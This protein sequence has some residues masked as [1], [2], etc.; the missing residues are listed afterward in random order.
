MTLQHTET[1]LSAQ[2][3]IRTKYTWLDFISIVMHSVIITWCWVVATNNVLELSQ[4][5]RFYTN[6]KRS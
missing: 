2:R 4:A 5:N 6:K 3:W 1:Q